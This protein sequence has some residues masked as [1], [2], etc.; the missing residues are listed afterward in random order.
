MRIELF[1]GWYFLFLLGCAGLVCLL[2]FSL[3]KASEKIQKWV[4]FS[5]L[6]LSVILHF[7]KVLYPP[8]S[9]DS[10]RMLRDSWFINICGA[11]IALFPIFFWCKN[12]SLK[13]YMFYLGVLGGL[14]AVVYPMEVFAK[15]D[16]VG[17]IWDILRFYFHHTMLFAVPFCMLMFKLHKLSYKRVLYIPLC[18][19]SVCAFCMLNQVMQAELGFIPM[20]GED[21]LEIHYKNSSLIWGL[22]VNERYPFITKLVPNFLKT[23]PFGPNAGQTKYWP[24]LW[25]IVPLYVYFVPMVFLL[26][27]IFDFKNFKNDFD[28]L[29]NTIRTKIKSR[30]EKKSTLQSSQ[31]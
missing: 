2:Y 17:E 29:I 15:A 5:I 10:S 3:R 26:S 23:I 9:T 21:I 14:V 20:R 7:T 25:A 18:F 8:Y 22:D 31:D 24:L 28:S 19:M 6:I 11:N 13:D 16:Q 12:K 4:L 1:N 30:K 27:L